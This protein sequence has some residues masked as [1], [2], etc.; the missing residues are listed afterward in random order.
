MAP[1]ASHRCRSPSGLRLLVSSSRAR[2]FS[3]SGAREAVRLRT[4]RSFSFATGP[5]RASPSGVLAERMKMSV[6]L[7]QAIGTRSSC[8]RRARMNREVTVRQ[9]ADGRYA[10]AQELL[11]L[12][13]VIDSVLC[14][15]GGDY[16]AVIEAQSVNFALKS[17]T[18]REAIMAG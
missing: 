11:P 9:T 3:P 6:S 5:C 17:E 8:L 18:E 15:R 4:G 14:L 16:R 12:E 2:L 7:S 13:D 10:S 1:P